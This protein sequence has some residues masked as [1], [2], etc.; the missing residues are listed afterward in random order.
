[1]LVVCLQRVEFYAGS[2]C[3]LSR[4]VQVLHSSFSICY[5]FPESIIF[6]ALQLHLVFKVFCETSLHLEL[7]CKQ[8]YISV[9]LLKQSIALVN[10]HNLY[11]YFVLAFLKLQ[12]MFL[13][14]FL[15]NC[16]Y[17]AK[18]FGH[19]RNLTNLCMVNVCLA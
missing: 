6:T 4:S 12:F 13:M 19:V 11:F 18:F 16:I 9:P 3:T 10:L 7:S 17:L 5:L 1:V 2:A 14:N 8:L 15:L